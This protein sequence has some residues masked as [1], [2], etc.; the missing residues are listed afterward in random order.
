MK[1]NK[2]IAYICFYTNDKQVLFLLIL[3]FKVL[4][5]V[6]VVVKRVAGTSAGAILAS[7]I[8]AG[9]TVAEIGE[10]MKMDLEGLMMGKIVSKVVFQL[11]TFH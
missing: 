8:A 10:F 1:T 2:N 9:Y 6:G 11:V 5:E 7:L 4:E 3:H